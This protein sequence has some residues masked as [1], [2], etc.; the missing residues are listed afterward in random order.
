MP[1]IYDWAR[2][3]EQVLDVIEGCRDDELRQALA[4][5]FRTRSHD[6]LAI[7]FTKTLMDNGMQPNETSA[8][9]L[10]NAVELVLDAYYTDQGE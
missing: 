3:P 8:H 6:D 7:E 10:A 4:W 9:A 5:L 1:S 2:H